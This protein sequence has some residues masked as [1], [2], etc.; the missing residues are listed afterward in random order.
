[1]NECLG[2]P[3]VVLL[4]LVVFPRA[5]DSCRLGMPLYCGA[6]PI[7]RQKPTMVSET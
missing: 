5:H 4:G 6:S 7:E 1:M 3:M 2:T